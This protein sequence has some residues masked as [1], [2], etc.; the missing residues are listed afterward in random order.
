MYQLIEKEFNSEITATS[1]VV[2]NQKV[3]VVERK[4]TAEQQQISAEQKNL[5]DEEEYRRLVGLSALLQKISE[6]VPV[7]IN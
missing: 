1:Q 6:S 7:T 3:L 5:E 2:N 4:W